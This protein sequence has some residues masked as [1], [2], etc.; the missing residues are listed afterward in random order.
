[1]ISLRRISK[2]PP[3]LAG[4]VPLQRSAEKAF[5]KYL[6]TANEFKFDF[7]L[8][9]IKR[10]L[11]LLKNPQDAFRVIHITGSNGKGSVAA[12]L[13]SILFRHGIKTGT[14]TSPHLKHPSERIAVSGMPVDK[15]QMAAEGLKL[16]KFASAKGVR[17]TYFEFMTVLAFVMF[18]KLGIRIGVIEVG[19]GGRYDATNVDYRHKLLSIITS[20]SLEHTNYLGHTVKSI[21]KE[22]EKIIKNEPA[23]CNIK[24]ANLRKML[25]L[26]HHNGV[27][28]ADEICGISDVRV[29]QD[30]L[31]VLAH[32][33]QS[34]D[35]GQGPQFYGTDRNLLIKTQLPEPVQA[36]NIR[37]TLAAVEMLKKHGLNLDDGCVVKGIMETSVPGRLTWDAGGYYTSVAHNPAA[38][39]AMLDGVKRLHPG[40]KL[41]YVFSMLGDK[42]I[43]GVLKEIKKHKNVVI[44]LTS[45][46]NPRAISLEKLEQLVVKCG[47]KHWTEA[48][49]A[50]ALA[51]ARR[52]KGK[53][54][55]VVGGSFYLVRKFV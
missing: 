46:K 2:E 13:T 32:L 55:I 52:I 25:K 54:V 48:D 28:F 45:I 10:I 15:G 41:V 38:V 6:E 34:R 19:L 26:K 40:K 44:V 5:L 33:H 42:D 43:K 20:I 50:R 39:S 31:Y 9:R 24:P 17:L 53:G 12:F 18:R 36:E 14:Y 29:S 16:A 30:G 49:N 51:L 37:T 1:M 11:K 4:G 27:C 21:L 23:V 47:I 8:S 35:C 22:K 3:V 7:S